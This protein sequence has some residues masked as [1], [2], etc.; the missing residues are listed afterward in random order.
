VH[1]VLKDLFLLA[2][3]ERPTRISELIPSPLPET[4]GVQDAAGPGMDGVHFVPLYDG[5]IMP[6]L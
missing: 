3:E 1:T 4:I 6:M 5:S 2:T